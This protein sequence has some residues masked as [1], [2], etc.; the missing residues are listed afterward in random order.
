MSSMRVAL[1]ATLAS[2]ATLLFVLWLSVCVG[3]WRV[4]FGKAYR[5][6]MKGRRRMVPVPGEHRVVNSTD[7]APISYWGLEGELPI[8]VVVAPG[9]RARAE[10]AA[11][12]A[13]EINAAGFHVAMVQ[14]RGSSPDDTMAVTFGVREQHDLRSV[15]R[16]VRRRYPEFPIAL[17]GISF[18]ASMC[19]L[20]AAQGEDVDAL[21][22]DG[23]FLDPVSVLCD[24]VVRRLHVAVGPLVAWPVAW[25]LRITRHVRIW[26]VAIDRAARRVP[27]IPLHVL[28]YDA[29]K[30]VPFRRSVAVV[31]A[32][33]WADNVERI[34]NLGHVYAFEDD[35]PL[36]VHKLKRFLYESCPSLR[37]LLVAG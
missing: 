20:A 5:H 28:I 34:G 1:I 6:S 29:D 3:T 24:A 26:E 36:Y 15:I 18:G 12:L 25:V 37:R 30:L 14:W 10:E 4:F 9:Y 32:A 2:V 27:D 33:G 23:P 17:V 22:L 13:A 21:W 7:G 8:A 16:D 19:I 35:P 31:D 11:P